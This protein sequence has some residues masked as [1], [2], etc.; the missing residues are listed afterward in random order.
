MSGEALH[1]IRLEPDML[2]A[3]AWGAERKLLKPG[4]DDGYLWHAL[5]LAAFGTEFAPRPFRFVR[6]A[7]GR[8]ARKPPYLVGYVAAAQA[9]LAEQAA[10]FADPAAV[11]ALNVNSLAAKRM[12]ECFREGLRL[13]FEVRVRP[14]VRTARGD[15]LQPGG[16]REID[17]F[18]AATL[19]ITLDMPVDRETVY[20]AWLSDRLQRGGAMLEEKTFRVLSLARS[21]DL[22]HGAMGQNGERSFGLTG[23]SQD[24]GGKPEAVLAGTLYV[25]DPSAFLALLRRGVGRHRAFG[26]GMLLL[27]PPDTTLRS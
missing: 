19:A 18:L 27:S 14:L 6:P 10:L 11:A 2:R 7:A 9:A 8:G 26:F 22:R 20:R 24:R 25:A 5:L 17:A 4:V 16:G 21:R 23:S 12:P 1:M 3:A 13:G 15:A